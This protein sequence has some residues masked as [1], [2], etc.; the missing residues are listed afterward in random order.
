MGGRKGERRQMIERIKRMHLEREMKGMAGGNRRDK[1]ITGCLS[2]GADPVPD[3][4]ESMILRET[5]QREGST[6]SKA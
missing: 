3:I 6:R 2:L 4:G 5:D 1:Y